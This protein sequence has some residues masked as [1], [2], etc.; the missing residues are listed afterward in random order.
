VGEFNKN[1]NIKAVIQACSKIRNA[2]TPIKLICVGGD[3]DQLAR[4]CRIKHL[5]DWIEVKGRLTDPY[6]LAQIY[7]QSAFLVVPALR[8]T[9]GMVF[10]EALSQGC[11]IVYSK[12]R[13][14]HGFFHEHW[15]HRAV[16]PRSQESIKAAILDMGVA[17]EERKSEYWEIQLEFFQMCRVVEMYRNAA[18]DKSHAVPPI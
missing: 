16:D 17:R 14:V 11:C 15:F 1:K 13:A 10:L 12:D 6:E 9:F 18:E 3:A 5:P 8:E 7:R 2:G 4:L